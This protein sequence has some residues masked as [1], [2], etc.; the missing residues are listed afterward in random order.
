[1]AWLKRDP[2]F[3]ALLGILV[4]SAL[5]VGVYVL[6]TGNQAKAAVQ[7]HAR[8]LA[9][10][11]RLERQ[12][13][14]PS[15]SNVEAMDL[16]VQMAG[17]A[18]EEMKASIAVPEPAAVFEVPPET[19]TEAFFNLARYVEE[20]RRRAAEAGVAIA[21][22]E[23]F[24]FGQ[25]ATEGPDA[26]VIPFVFRQ[27]NIGKVILEALFAARP[28]SMERFQ[29][30]NPPGVQPA[31]ELFDMPDYLSARRNGAVSAIG[32]RVAFRGQTPTLRAF[33]NALAT[34][35]VP[36]VVRSVEVQPVGAGPGQPPPQQRPT[37]SFGAPSA[38]GEPAPVTDIPIVTANT[39]VFTVTL[40][41][42]E[43]VEPAASN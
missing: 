5:G 31:A 40:E 12:E 25:Y 19:R 18:Y 2:I 17:A 3:S 29:R 37:F 24:G 6:I 38:E 28:E 26:A 16:Q 27:K 32:F 8:R 20:M 10:L 35:P 13:P 11:E 9:V 1:M 39:S 43:V 33:L 14:Y 4:L 42:V 7:E 23:S 34:S 36:L 41:F 21:A 22:N 30:E 15:S